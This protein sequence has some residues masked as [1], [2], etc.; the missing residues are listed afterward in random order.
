VS[1]VLFSNLV[2]GTERPGSD[3]DLMVLG[4][5]SFAE[6]ARA[7]AAPQTTLR[8]E[9]NPTLMTRAE[10]TDK[11]AQGDSFV[12]SVMKGDKLWLK[13]GERDLAEPAED[14]APEAAPTQRRRGAAAAGGGQPKPDRRRRPQHQR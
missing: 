1:A 13:G 4:K 8:R 7:L 10:F 6:L 12:R 11:L 2:S 14:R 9:V 5:A 3:V